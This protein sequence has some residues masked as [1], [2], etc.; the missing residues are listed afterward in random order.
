MLY[1]ASVVDGSKV[2]PFKQLGDTP[3]RVVFQLFYSPA[4]NERWFRKGAFECKVVGQA[5]LGML[6]SGKGEMVWGRSTSR[7]GVARV[8]LVDFNSNYKD[9]S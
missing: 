6:W 9:M 8:L 4:G 5:G 1:N 2:T 7:G 3:A